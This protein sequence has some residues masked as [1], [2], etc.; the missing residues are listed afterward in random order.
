M[1][2]IPP[3]IKGFVADLLHPPQMAICSICKELKKMKWNTAQKRYQ[4]YCSKEC[5]WK[6]NKKSL[7]KF[8]GF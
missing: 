7:F 2:V 1:R 8:K 5:T 6:A 4:K 3:K